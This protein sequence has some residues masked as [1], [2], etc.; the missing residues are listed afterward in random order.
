MYMYINNRMI[1]RNNNGIFMNVQAK[2]AKDNITWQIF[3]Y[4]Y[5]FK[6]K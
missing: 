1:F 4:I 2:I 3:P 6:K 5:F